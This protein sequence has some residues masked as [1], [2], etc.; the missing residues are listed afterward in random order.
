[1]A[2]LQKDILCKECFKKISVP[3][4]K[5]HTCKGLCNYGLGISLHFSDF[6][7]IPQINVADEFF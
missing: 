5:L 2:I 6:K 7:V 3:N 1:M 4:N